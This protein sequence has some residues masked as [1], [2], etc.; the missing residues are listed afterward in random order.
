MKKCV[1]CNRAVGNAE[2]GCPECGGDVIVVRPEVSR[3]DHENGV[4]KPLVLA[5]I[6]PRQLADHQREPED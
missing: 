5:P 4:S 1:N 3:S 6:G 2:D